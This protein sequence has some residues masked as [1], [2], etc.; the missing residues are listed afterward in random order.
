MRDTVEPNSDY[1][2]PN[3]TK[4]DPSG[5]E[6]SSRGRFATPANP[7]NMTVAITDGY[8]YASRV[9]EV[10]IVQVNSLSPKP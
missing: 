6:M 8:T 3:R 9:C 5:W 7:S 1:F 4:R 10:S 2:G